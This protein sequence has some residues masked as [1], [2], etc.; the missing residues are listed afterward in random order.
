[1]RRTSALTSTVGSSPHR[2][3]LTLAIAA[4]AA[5]ALAACGTEKT[6]ADGPQSKPADTAEVRPGAA[7]TAMLDKVAQSCP[8]SAPPEAPPTGPAQTPPPGSVETPP[9]MEP[10]APTAGPE[11]ELNAHDWCASALHEERIAQAL[12]D[13]ADPTPTR[14]RTILND[15]GY[16]DERI[17][18]L[19]QSG[20][21]TRFLLDLRD[22]GGRL[23]LEGSA[24][25]E[26]T[27]VDKCVAPATGPFT[28]GERKQ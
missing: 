19:R 21:T 3:R 26:N 22:K 8:T 13:L 17:H 11:V 25:G 10:I 20:A 28:P 4:G 5:L 16:V 27:V 14:V 18:D 12:W 6:G 24:A 1:M 9:D 7:F 2:P 23:C 15:L